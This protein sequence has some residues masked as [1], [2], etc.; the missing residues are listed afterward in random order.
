[1]AQTGIF[2]EY[3]IKD[4]L[5]SRP[6]ATAVTPGTLYGDENGVIYRSDGTTWNSRQSI[7]WPTA[8]AYFSVTVRP[9]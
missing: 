2:E 9:A 1:M 7:R 8:I 4:L 3:I 6:A 5:A